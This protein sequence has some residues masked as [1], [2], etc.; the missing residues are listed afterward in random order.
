MSSRIQMAG[1]AAAIASIVAIVAWTF[2]AWLRPQMLLAI[3]T[4]LSFCG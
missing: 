2:A 3:L 4:S 1:M